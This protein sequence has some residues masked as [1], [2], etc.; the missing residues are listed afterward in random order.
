VCVCEIFTQLTRTT[1][2]FKLNTNCANSNNEI[3]VFSRV[4]KSFLHEN[5]LTS[6]K[7]SSWS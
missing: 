1:Q 3:L 6:V 7:L 4:R 5:Q 2:L